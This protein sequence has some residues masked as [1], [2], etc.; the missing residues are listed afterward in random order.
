MIENIDHARDRAKRDVRQRDGR[1]SD[2]LIRSPKPLAYCYLNQRLAYVTAGLPKVLAIHYA[3]A[4][5]ISPFR[6]KL[7]R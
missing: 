5:G 4:I 1:G 7:S 6:N 2:K 3:A